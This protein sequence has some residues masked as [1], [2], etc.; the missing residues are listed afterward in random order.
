LD[1]DPGYRAAIRKAFGP[2][3][4]SLTEGDGTAIDRAKLGSVIFSSPEKRRLLN[5]LSHPRI[6][7]RILVQLFK[8]KFLARKPMVVLDAPLL[9]ESKVLAYF[10]YPIVVVY[11]DDSQKQ[12]KR[13]MDRTAQLGVG[14]LSEEEAMRKI[15]SQMPISLKIKKAD[16]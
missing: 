15:S 2:E 16:I 13:L 10:C 3:V 1:K 9:F 11:C 8:L 14:D 4:F 5:K 7:R 6:F 12:L